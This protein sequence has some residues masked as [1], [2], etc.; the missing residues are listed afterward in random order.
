MRDKKDSNAAIFTR[1]MIKNVAVYDG[2]S[3]ILSNFAP[4]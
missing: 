1:A 2:N 3:Y 4:S